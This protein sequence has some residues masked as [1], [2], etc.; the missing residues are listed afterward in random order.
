ME[1]SLCEENTFNGLYSKNVKPLRN[2]IYYKCGELDKANDIVQDAFIK[3]WQNCSSVLFEKSV[4]YLY[5]VAKRLMYNLAR[6]NKV[7]LHFEKNN[8]YNHTDNSPEYILQ[9]KEFETR[10]ETAISNL[11]ELQRITFLMN[12]IDKLTYEEIALKQEVS[13]KAIE[14]RMNQALTSLKNELKELKYLKI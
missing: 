12:R 13:V 5:T 7:V 6:H 2:Y 9:E 1:L 8:F 14:K 4:A 10:L 3:L 11:P